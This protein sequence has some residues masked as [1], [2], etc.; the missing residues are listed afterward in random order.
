VKAAEIK[1]VPVN[2]AAA[3]ASTTVAK[4]TPPAA[5]PSKTAETAPSITLK[6]APPAP[7][8]AAEADKPASAP[9]VLPPKTAAK[10]AVPGLR[11]SANAY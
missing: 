3:P 6:M 11:M 1:P 2:A 7:V 10:D 8:K 9:R 4:A 5:G